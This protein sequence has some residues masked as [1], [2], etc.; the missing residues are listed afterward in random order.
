MN[1]TCYL[2]HFIIFVLAL[3]YTACLL[4]VSLRTPRDAAI[5]KNSMDTLYTSCT[6]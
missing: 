5:A 2:P 4:T 1:L 3:I 6:A